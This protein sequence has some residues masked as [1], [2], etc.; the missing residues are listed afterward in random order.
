[1]NDKSDGLQLMSLHIG[2]DHPKS[3]Q[4]VMN[5]LNKLLL[6]RCLLHMDYE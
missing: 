5:D 4:H 6:Q 3:P 1:M 2:G